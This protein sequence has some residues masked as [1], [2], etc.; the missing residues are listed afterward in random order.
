MLCVLAGGLLSPLGMS[1]D[2]AA[3]ERTV[4][5]AM[6]DRVASHAGVALIKLGSAHAEDQWVTL[7][8][9]RA[10]GV[11]GRGM[12][13]A[14]RLL[15]FGVVQLLARALARYVDDSSAYEAA[16]MSALAMVAIAATSPANAETVDRKGG[17]AALQRA[18]MA[19]SSLARA[20]GMEYPN[21][22]GWLAGRAT[23]RCGVHAARVLPPRDV[24][25][26]CLV[27]CSKVGGASFFACGGSRDTLPPQAESL[28]LQAVRD[29]AA[30]RKQPAPSQ[31]GS[32]V[33][34]SGA[35]PAA[36]TAVSGA[37]QSATPRPA[38]SKPRAPPPVARPP[39][40]QRVRSSP[41][42]PSPLPPTAQRQAARQAAPPAQPLPGEE[43]DDSQVFG[44]L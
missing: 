1:A 27:R 16:H 6:C 39:P 25:T 22:A 30:R 23:A 35:T 7:A 18:A 21:M 12:V 36:S 32:Y 15:D 9:S 40:P 10:L 4:R 42:A 28:W 3:R 11:I 43:Y 17:R 33:S 41:P 31:A 34:R 44:Q 24:L 37:T 13:A 8:V 38:A 19:N 20:L 29:A 2:A 14:H 5:E 26:T